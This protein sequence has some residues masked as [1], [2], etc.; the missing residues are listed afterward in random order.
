VNGKVLPFADL[1]CDKLRGVVEASTSD[2][3]RG[4]VLLGRA[5]GR[6]LAHE[7]YHITADTSE[8]GREGVAQAALTL[9]ELTSGSLELHASEV[10]AVANGLS[11]VR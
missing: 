3:S 2:Q 8:H 11:R 4:N 1:A 7:L 10:A 9:N 5:M 6:V